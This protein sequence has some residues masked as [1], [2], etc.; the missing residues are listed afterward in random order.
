LLNLGADALA[1]LTDITHREPKLAGR[2]VEDL[3]AL[4]ERHGD[5][6]MRDA[7]RRTVS[8]G[9]LTVM[10]VERALRGG[11]QLALPIVGATRKGGAS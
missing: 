11:R 3:F 7:I 9:K 8:A 10:A 1:L 6:A 5:D 4:L 2:R